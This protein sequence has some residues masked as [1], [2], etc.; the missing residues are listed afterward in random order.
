MS[1]PQPMPPGTDVVFGITCRDVLMGRGSRSKNHCGNVTYRKLV[2]LNKELY[3]KAS[4]FDK[5]KICKAIVA[6]ARH[7]GWRFLHTEVGG[8]SFEVGDERAWLKT[9]QT[10]REGIINTKA[11]LQAEQ[12]T[13]S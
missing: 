3:A 9:S 5:L 6:A 12:E 4:K 11:K 13:Y 7:F 8:K 2:D 10:L 1:D